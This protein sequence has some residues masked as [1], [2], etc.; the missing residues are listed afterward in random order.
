VRFLSE[1]E[2]RSADTRRPRFSAA[3]SSPNSQR[4]L[5]TPYSAGN[6]AIQ[7]LFRSGAIQAS[8]SIGTMDDP[9]EREADSMAARVLDHSPGKGTPSSSGD[10]RGQIRRQPEH[11]SSAPQVPRIVSQ[12]LRSSGHPLDVATRSFFEPRFGR[13]FSDVHI[14]TGAAAAASAGSIHARAYTSASDIVF[15]PNQFSPDS[16]SG[17]SLL[18][19]ELAHV[20]QQTGPSASRPGTSLIQRAPLPQEELPDY[21]TPDTFTLVKTRRLDAS[22]PYTSELLYLISGSWTRAS[23]FKDARIA[24]KIVDALESSDYFVSIAAQLDAYYRKHPYPR[25]SVGGFFKGTAYHPAGSPIDQPDSTQWID[26]DMDYIGIDFRRAGIYNPDGPQ[27]SDAAQV[28]AFASAIIHET[29]HAYDHIKGI[30]ASGLGGDLDEEQRTRRAEMKGLQQI[31]KGTKD[32]ELVEE[33]DKRIDAIRDAGLSKKKIA[34]DLI[35]AGDFTYVESYYVG[36]ATAE[37]YAE[38]KKAR[39]VQD[40]N[41]PIDAALKDLEKFTDADYPLYEAN[42]AYLV[43]MNAPLDSDPRGR[44]HMPVTLA[45]RHLFERLLNATTLREL[46]DAP[47]PSMTK[48]ERLLFFHILTLKTYFIRKEIQNAWAEFLADP[49]KRTAADVAEK[50]AR[51]FLGRRG[52]YKKISD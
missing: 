49:G 25:I 13:D 36:E 47:R 45:N 28:A 24:Q 8:L 40:A 6:Q 4:A 20:V 26:P 46:T 44:T 5:A 22:G 3:P 23:A 52:I 50:N 42:A 11:F 48:E 34:V 32:K 16:P 30:T 38:M 29:T 10:P 12:V 37:F 14:H 19:H 15:G 43:A 17:R 35:S 27:P 7:A 39:A 2:P 1:P 41:S 21:L 9:A 33:I 31:R 18:A 51:E